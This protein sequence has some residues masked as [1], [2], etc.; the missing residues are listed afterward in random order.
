MGLLL[1]LLLLGDCRGQ[2]PFYYQDHNFSY[3][4]E[5]N[6][7]GNQFGHSE[8]SHAGDTEGTYH[9]LLPDGRLQT[10]EYTVRRH[11]G[12]Q[13]T[14]QYQGIARSVYQPVESQAYSYPSPASP[15]HPIQP[16]SHPVQHASHPAQQVS[17]PVQHF[18]HPVQPASHPVQ[19]VSHPIQ[20]VSHPI[21]AFT[22]FASSP[23]SQPAAT[24]APSLQYFTQATSPHAII[25]RPVSYQPAPVTQFDP[26]VHNLLVSAPV[27]GYPH[28]PY[29]PPRLVPLSPPEHH[30]KDEK[31]K[32]E[33]D[34]Y[35]MTEE[36]IKIEGRDFSNPFW[37]PQHRKILR[38]S[39]KEDPKGEQHDHKKDP[40][41]EAESENQL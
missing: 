34:P 26:H 11:A 41:N 19:Q 13:A 36:E 40:E 29:P 21:P 32:K 30:E 17:H 5:D 14:V 12:F 33:K 7:S 2:E 28:A 31:K 38:K 18:S 25:Y 1:L 35:L 6:S 39:R 10:V 9:V 20:Q 15:S 24:T 8:T 23:P 16:A 37:Y 22:A 3:S 4:V 27:H